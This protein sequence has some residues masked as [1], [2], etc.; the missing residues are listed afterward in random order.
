MTMKLK[1][2]SIPRSAEAGSPFDPTA[3]T[4]RTGQ[5]K[6]SKTPAGPRKIGALDE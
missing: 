4:G 3:G 2:E 5:V 6:G 1:N